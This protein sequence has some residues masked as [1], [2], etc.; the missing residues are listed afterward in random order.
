MLIPI[1]TTFK[2][3]KQD[4]DKEEEIQITFTRLQVTCPIE[5]LP[6]VIA[7]IKDQFTRRLDMAAK[8]I[9]DADE[10][11]INRKGNA[12]SITYDEITAKNDEITTKQPDQ[13]GKKDK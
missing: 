6:D 4:D 7:D 13:K 1:L 3:L 5:Q 9:A 11:I 2:K 12:S 8:R 10:V